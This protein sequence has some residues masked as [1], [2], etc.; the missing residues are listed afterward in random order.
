M[1]GL[2]TRAVPIPK[3]RVP[4]HEHPGPLLYRLREWVSESAGVWFRSFAWVS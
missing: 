3:S 2:V 4:L 1:W